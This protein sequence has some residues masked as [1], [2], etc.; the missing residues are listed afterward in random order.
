[1]TPELHYLVWS[2]ALT[3][4]LAVIAVSGAQLQV[5]LPRLAGNRENIPEFTG[6]QEEPNAPTATC[7]RA[8]CCLRFWYSPPRL[9]A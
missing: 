1:M 4:I 5:G 6:W 2:A 7:W 8:W 3:L 9:R